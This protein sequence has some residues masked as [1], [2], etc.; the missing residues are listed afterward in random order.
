MNNMAV[1]PCPSIFNYKWANFSN[2]DTEGLNGLKN[3]IH[4]YAALLHLQGHTQT[5]SEG[6]ETDV[7][8]NRNQKRTGVDKLLS[9]KIAFKTK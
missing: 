3:K 1:S 4:V 9:D 2:Q 5:E 7:P 8:L 6:A